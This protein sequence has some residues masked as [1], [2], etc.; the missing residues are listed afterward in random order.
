LTDGHVAQR[1]GGGLHEEA[2]EA[3]A[4]AVLLLEQILVAAAR[5]HHRGHVD[6]VE[7]G[8]QRGGVLRFL[9]A[10]AMVWRRRVIR[11]RS[12][13]RSPARR[14]GGAAAAGACG[15][16]AG[17]GGRRRG[18]AA[19]GWFGGGEHVVLGEAAVLAGALDLGRVEAVLEHQ[20]A[21]R[22]GQGEAAASAVV[23]LS[24]RGSTFSCGSPSGRSRRPPAD[25]RRSGGCGG[26]RRGAAAPA[27]FD[28]GDQRADGDRVAFGDEL[29]AHRAGDRRGHLDRDLVGLEAGDRLVGRDRVA[30]LL[31]P[32]A[33]R[34][35][36]DRFPERRDG[37]VGRPSFLIPP[38]CGCGFA[39]MA[40]RVG[41]QGRLLR[42]VALGKAGRRRGRGD[43]ARIDAAAA[44]AP[45]LG[46][47]L[48]DQGSTKNQ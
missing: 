16:A 39:A 2:H 13:R 48:L 43:A 8:E 42:R 45:G 27:R 10:A 32:L 38:C 22:R 4:D 34:R 40:E 6:V 28:P 17:A 36:G 19:A 47:A 15:G 7:G 12:S 35:F 3:E 25:G 26:G 30:R 18:R 20:A 29:L 11:T 24:S 41:D 33:E 44:A 46:E 37:D 23:R 9:E 21:H 14:R 1:P 5:L 31:Q